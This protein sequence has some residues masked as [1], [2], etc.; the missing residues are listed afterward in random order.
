MGARTLRTLGRASGAASKDPGGCARRR[1]AD[2]ARQTVS[3]TDSDA[4]RQ[5]VSGTDSD[6]A[7]LGAR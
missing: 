5:T 6:A 7:R 2:A 4:A 1:A 3:G